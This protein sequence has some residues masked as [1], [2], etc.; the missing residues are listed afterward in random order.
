M[1]KPELVSPAGDFEK[2]QMAVAYGADAVYIGGSRFSLRKNAKNFDEPSLAE[3]ISF[4]HNHGVKVYVAANIFA[5]NA[6]FDGLKDYFLALRDM[7]A[8]A[9]IVSDAGVFDIARNIDGLPVHI[10]TQANVTNKHSAKFYQ[11]LGA[12]RAVLAR[13]LSLEEIKAINV[14]ASNFETEVFVHGAMCV[15]YSGRCLLSN[16]LTKRD[17][18][19]GDCVQACRWKYSLVEEERPGEYMPTY[20][21]E[22]GTHIFNAKDLCMVTHIPELIASGVLS[23]KIVGRA[24]TAY[25]VAAATKIYRE[26]IDDYFTCPALYTSK[27]EYYVTN[28]TKIATRDFCTGFFFG[29]PKDSQM[30]QFDSRSANQDFLGVVVKYDAEKKR[31]LIQQ[32]NKF[33]CGD[34]VAF[35]K[36]GFMQTIT[37]IHSENNELLDLA[38]HPKQ[39]VWIPAEQPL[40]PFEI[41][42]TN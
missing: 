21:D 32:R 27:C 22:R 38:R 34:T 16:Y 19:Q 40:E 33:R 30:L 10:S 4:A 17:A 8:D 3:A 20:E 2:L 37:Q 9:V 29:H 42:R 11:S 28:L 26:A 23:F 15:A 24:K 1:L 41:M 12:K 25:Y 35:L 39:L 5:H 18:N 14:Y 13:E 31:A 7:N 36:A 6:D